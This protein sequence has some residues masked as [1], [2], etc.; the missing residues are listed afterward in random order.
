QRGSGPLARY[1]SLTSAQ[2]ILHSVS[3]PSRSIRTRLV[4]HPH[5]V[6]GNGL[7]L[8]GQGFTFPRR[9]KALMNFSAFF[10]TGVFGFHRRGD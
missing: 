6:L 3:D 10:M 2:L 9:V 5:N 1:R 7:S 4:L 8:R